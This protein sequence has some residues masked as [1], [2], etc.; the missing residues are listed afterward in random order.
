MS[1]HDP[2]R[3]GRHEDQLHPVAMPYHNRVMKGPPGSGVGDLS[4]WVGPDEGGHAVTY[5][6][7]ALDDTLRAKIE[8]GA[9]VAVG[10]WTY[11]MPPIACAVEGPFCEL[12]KTE[13]VWD[14]SRY[15]CPHCG[16]GGSDDSRDEG[17]QSERGRGVPEDLRRDF[18]PGDGE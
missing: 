18:R 6:A 7:F 14:G 15:Y 4:T 8:A 17:S 2:T 13:K 12:H 10:L 5:M 9:H 3:E 11:P 1:E 16:E